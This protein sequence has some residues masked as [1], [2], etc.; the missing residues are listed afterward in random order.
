MIPAVRIVVDGPPVGKGRPRF[1]R[2]SGRAFTPAKTASYEAILAHAAGEAMAGRP[3]L[4]GPVRVT[5][6]AYMTIPASWSKRKTEE[7]LV[8]ILRPGKPD[9]DNLLKTLDAFNGIVWRDD[10]QVAEAQISKLYDPDPRFEVE[11]YPLGWRER[12]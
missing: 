8:G 10:A 3:P 11:V 12:Q 4:D 5:A 7:A 1:I 9:A 6:T 2:A